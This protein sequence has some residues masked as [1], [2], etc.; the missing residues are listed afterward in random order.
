MKQCVGSSN[1]CQ[2]R[3]LFG[4][5]V[6]YCLKFSFGAAK[7]KHIQVNSS[8]KIVLCEG[9]FIRVLLMVGWAIRREKDCGYW[10]CVFNN[11]LMDTLLFI[12]SSNATIEYFKNLYLYCAKK[13]L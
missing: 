4:A 1:G 3:G 11:R 6:P 12:L 10:Y 8:L 5:G 9:L 2:F 7:E 13:H